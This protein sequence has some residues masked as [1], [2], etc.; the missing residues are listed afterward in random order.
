M[1]NLWMIRKQKIKKGGL[2]THIMATD[3]NYPLVIWSPDGKVVGVIYEKRARTFVM[4]YNIDEKKKRKKKLQGF[5]E[6]QMHLLEKI[7]E[8]LY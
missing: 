8:Q 7:I 1:Y 6:L 4:T 2:K 5:K 3:L